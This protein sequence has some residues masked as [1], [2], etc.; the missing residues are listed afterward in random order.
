VCFNN[1][2]FY[3]CTGH[4]LKPCLALTELRGFTEPCLKTIV[5]KSRCS[6]AFV[7]T[8]EVS[9]PANQAGECCLLVMCERMMLLCRLRDVDTSVRFWFQP[10]TNDEAL[11]VGRAAA[12]QAVIEFQTQSLASSHDEAQ[13]FRHSRCPAVIDWTK[14]SPTTSTDGRQDR[15]H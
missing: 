7:K 1:R 12:A 2:Y 9:Q 6:P 3:I 8:A 15:G 14:T 10:I 5:L 4:R 13:V 11:H